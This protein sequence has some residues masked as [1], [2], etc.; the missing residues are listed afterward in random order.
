LSTS[1]QPIYLAQPDGSRIAYHRTPGR[2]PGVVFLCGFLSDMTAT[3]AITLEKWCKA[4]KQAF[5]R[6]DYLGHGA[7]NGRFEEGT[8]GRWTEDALGV[9]DQLTEGPQVLVGS[10]MGG[11]I[12]LL[13]ARE[14]PERI[15]G[16]VGIAPAPDF[17][18]D[19][20]WGQFDASVR[21]QL[22][23]QGIVRLPSEYDDSQVPVTLQLIQ[24]GR[25]HQLL[26]KPLPL[27]C[28]VR[29]LHGMQDA[30]V[31]WQTSI[32]IAERVA[33]DDVRVILVKDGEHRLSRESDLNLLTETLGELTRGVERQIHEGPS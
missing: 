6:F 7:S 28:P 16:L 31:P 15:A 5:I 32:R 25:A 21:T 4:Q 13:V 29:L 20:L 1:Q 23:S 10:S 30:D 33:S 8:I 17:T 3:K 14:R 24:E 27:T 26:D 11:W 18:E 12:M 9:L 22:Q 2:M 19:L